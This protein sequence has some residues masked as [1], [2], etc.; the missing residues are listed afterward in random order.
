M[1]AELWADV[2]GLSAG[3]TPAALA[4]V[5]TSAV[6]TV[7]A[8][9]DQLADWK[10]V[11]R[12][13]LACLVL[14]P[15]ELDLGDSPVDLVVA[16][17]PEILQALRPTADGRRLGVRCEIADGAGMDA[18]A[19]LCGSVDVLVAAFADDTNIPLELLLARAQ[20]THTRVLKELVSSAEAATVVGVLESGP[21]GIVIRGDQLGDLDRVGEALR[22]RR[23]TRRDMVALEVTRAES[24]GMGHRGCIDT[25]TLFGEDEGMVVGST[26]SGGVLVCAEVHHLPY[27]NLRPF[28]VNAGAVHSYVFGADETAYITD[29]RAGEPTY[30]VSAG[31]RFREVLV[32]RVK[33]ELRPLRLIEARHGDTVV[34]V[35]L[36][37]DWHVRV[38]G[39]EGRPLNLTE[40]RPGTQ[41][42]G[43]VCR[44]GR[45]VGIKVEEQID[46]F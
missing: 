22:A 7:L 35:L 16:G 17:T 30:A 46:E 18:A 33:V 44:P 4:R 26:S 20:G 28:R 34:N 36:Q 43:T 6:T 39:A 11:E 10:P 32:G 42:L 9:L 21:A 45:H 2:S 5:R 3:A 8:R 31:G 29:L 15:D 19:A 27:M 25:A 41:L 1:E 40:V 38:M 37:D 24:V 12:T 23:E 13:T 14:R